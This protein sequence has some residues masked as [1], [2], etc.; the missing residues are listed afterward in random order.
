MYACCMNYSTYTNIGC[1]CIL[2]LD[3]SRLTARWRHIGLYP[4]NHI[5]GQR[6][7]SKTLNIRLTSSYLSCHLLFSCSG[8]SQHTMKGFT[9][10]LQ[11]TPHMVSSKVG[12]SAKSTDVE[13][14]HLRHK[15]EA[16]EKLIK[17]LARESNTYLSAV[18]SAYIARLTN[19]Q[20]C[21][22]RARRLP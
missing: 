18:K 20:K 7:L 8:L 1:I 15:F 5:I 14:D 3:E 16:M 19:M 2:Y 11:R 10:F 17:Q 4:P 21:S 13:F 12:I 22:S 6:D 9:K